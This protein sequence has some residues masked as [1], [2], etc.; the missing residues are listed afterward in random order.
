MR[1]R[2][3]DDVD[4]KTAV[5]S[6]TEGLF[7]GR[8]GHP[9]KEFSWLGSAWNCKKKRKHYRSFCRN[10]ATISVHDFVYIMAEND[11]KL[12]AYVDDL[13]ED[14]RANRMVVVRWFHKVDEVGIV[15]PQDVSDREIF[16]SPCLQDLHV[17]CI[18]GLAAVLS[19]QDFDKFHSEARHRAGSWQPHLCRRQIDNDD[20]K[21]FDITQVQGYWSQELL[22]SI[23]STTGTSLK[24]RLKITHGGSKSNHSRDKRGGS[25]EI[26]MLNGSDNRSPG[27]ITDTSKSRSSSRGEKHT[28]MASTSPLLRKELLKQNFQQLQKHLAPGCHVEVLSQDSGMRGCWFRCVVLKRHH[29]KV[30]VRYEDVADAEDT[31]KL[32]EWILSSRVASPDKLGIRSSGRLVVRPDP[33]SCS[34][35]DSRIL[36]VGSIVDAWWHDGWWE[37]IVVGAEL[38]EL[39]RVYFPGE[40]RVSIFSMG[41]LRQ[42]REWNNNKW[43]ELV[44]RPD[45]VNSLLSD[46]DRENR[47]GSSSGGE[48]AVPTAG[49]RIEE[50]EM[51]VRGLDAAAASPGVEETAVTKPKPIS[52]PLLT[53]GRA[54]APSL[55]EFCQLHNLTWSSSK[56]RNKLEWSS[57]KKRR[58]AREVVEGGS[59]R[60]NKRRRSSAS[61]NSNNSRSQEGLVEAAT[62]NA[63]SE[64]LLAVIDNKEKYKTGGSNPM[65]VTP[66]L[67][68]CSNLVLSQ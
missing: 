12:V 44:D 46:I 21:P 45:M 28:K 17:E 8:T 5:T 19:T 22:R 35:M 36:D 65:L 68:L 23:Y 26:S 9:S 20:F 66:I 59:S 29:D 27:M 52:I 60:T 2:L 38:D 1:D 67:P 43:N 64:L 18:D 47:L 56:K 11:K 16:F 51:E 24:L 15:L 31:G 48:V 55:S 33:K 57:S 50:A 40:R 58:R 61:S 13:Y 39:L 42:S 62:S 49:L 14:M 54:Q 53:E 32:E 10:G 37:G 30:K 63:C 25:E 7:S 34:S 41:D 4:A 6:V 3:V